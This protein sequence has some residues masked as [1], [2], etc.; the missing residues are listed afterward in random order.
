MSF[1]V[2]RPP[3]EPAKRLILPIIASSWSMLADPGGAQIIY[4]ARPTVSR[5]HTP[6]DTVAGPPERGG[7]AFPLSSIA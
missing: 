4:S 1:V 6:G 2:G 5:R 3:E 7:E